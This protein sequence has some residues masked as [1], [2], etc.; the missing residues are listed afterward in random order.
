MRTTHVEHLQYPLAFCKRALQAQRLFCG[1][2]KTKQNR[3]SYRGSGQNNT[4]SKGLTETSSGRKEERQTLR[5]RRS[6]KRQ[7][8]QREERQR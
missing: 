3:K 6:R 7:E 4:E 2:E 5:D 8:R 1:G